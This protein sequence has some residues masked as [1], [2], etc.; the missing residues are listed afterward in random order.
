ML[1]Y[2]WHTTYGKLPKVYYL[3]TCGTLPTARFPTWG[4]RTLILAL[5]WSNV[6]RLNAKWRRLVFVS[7]CNNLCHYLWPGFEPMNVWLLYKLPP[8]RI[9][10]HMTA[11][12]KL[13]KFNLGQSGG[14]C[15]STWNWFPLKSNLFHFTFLLEI[16]NLAKRLR[17][18]GQ[19]SLKSFL[20]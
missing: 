15:K 1:K 13:Q 17:E 7:E 18:R 8:C 14:R 2:L 16:E 3:T 20:T 10:I 11:F 9:V 6:D 19:R 12:S 4:I 5:L